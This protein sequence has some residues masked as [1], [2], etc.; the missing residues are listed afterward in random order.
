M[1]TSGVW[2]SWLVGAY[3]AGSVPFGLLLGRLKGVDIR[4]YGSGNVGATNAGR[5]LGR[6][7]GIACFLLDVGKGLAP[8]LGYGLA[9]G[10]TEQGGAMGALGW[11][12]I[13]AAAV[14]G[15][16]FPVWLKFRGGKGVAT[17]LGVLLGYWPVLTVPGLVA[18]LIWV[19]VVKATGYVSLAS[20]VAAATLPVLAVASGLVLG[21]TAGEIAVFVG[22]TALLAGLVIVRHRGN[23]ARLRAGTEGK[24]AW[25]RRDSPA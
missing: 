12:A 10:P 20:M 7:W 4:Q 21:L 23:I 5:V 19:A 25:A 8:V 3:L 14:V 13:G 9:T 24:A 18:G 2:L 1:M 11:L 22:L 15:H 6:P 17:A 16:V